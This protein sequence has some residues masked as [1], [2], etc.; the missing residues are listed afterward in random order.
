MGNSP[1][2]NLG[3]FYRKLNLDCYYYETVNEKDFNELFYKFLDEIHSFQMKGED[4][5][6]QIYAIFRRNNV[7]YESV[8]VLY[9]YLLTQS[10]PLTKLLQLLNGS[11][12]SSN[13]KEPELI[14][15]LTCALGESYFLNQKKLL[16]QIETLLKE[17]EMTVKSFSE[18]SINGK[19]KQDNEVIKSKRSLSFLECKNLDMLAED[20]FVFR[21]IEIQCKSSRFDFKMTRII[22][23]KEKFLG[24]DY[25][26]IDIFVDENLQVRGKV[27]YK[28]LDGDK[29]S[30][31]LKHAKNILSRTLIE[32]N[33][34]HGQSEF[35]DQFSFVK[36][37]AHIFQ[38]KFEY[39]PLKKY[40]TKNSIIEP[41]NESSF[42]HLNRDH[43]IQLLN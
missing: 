11:T 38:S 4:L 5:K 14:Y 17:K 1:Y 41:V 10:S 30:F 43:F 40:F 3:E 7:I 22:Q 33:I 29:E 28:V 12:F 6:E 13:M 42:H 9:N 19:I 8:K 21:N 18:F 25:P 34:V 27:F 16:K 35:E 15:F 26:C 32:N 2:L 36:G 20:F 24:G 31:H 37:H 39:I 23:G